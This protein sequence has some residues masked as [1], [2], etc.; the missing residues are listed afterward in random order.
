MPE[1]HIAPTMAAMAAWVVVAAEAV[2]LL[3]ET[4]LDRTVRMA[5]QAERLVQMEETH[6]QLP[7]RPLGQV[8]PV[9]VVVGPADF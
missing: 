7:L 3:A 4:P 9:A 8:V 1:R 2:L 5:V 6:L